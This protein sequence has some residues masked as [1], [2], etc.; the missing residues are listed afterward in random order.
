MKTLRFLT[1]LCARSYLVGLVLFSQSAMAHS[2]YVFAQ[3][4]GQIL[5]GKSY[6]SD[7]TPAAET[8]FEVYKQGDEQP[9]LSSKTDHAGYFYLPLSLNSKT[10]LKVVVEGEEG[11]KAMVIAD[12]ITSNRED[13]HLILLREDIA[14]LRDKIYFHDILSGIGYIVGIIGI[15]AWLSA[16]RQVYNILK[17]LPTQAEY[18]Y[19]HSKNTK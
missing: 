6:Y 16:R 10:L 14:R 11:H 19:Q 2:L 5:S 3:Y 13:N 1:A 15:F 8:Y 12:R 9:M 4:D 17:C 7:M 18:T